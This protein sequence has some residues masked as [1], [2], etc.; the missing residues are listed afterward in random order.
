MSQSV[1]LIITLLYI[2]ISSISAL[3]NCTLT[4][5]CADQLIACASLACNGEE[6]CS[7]MEV[8]SAGLTTINCNGNVA[9]RGLQAM[10]DATLNP[11]GNNI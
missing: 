6:S 9:C 3:T 8:Y 2:T 7:Y 11:M 5:P 10:F 4:N 1:S